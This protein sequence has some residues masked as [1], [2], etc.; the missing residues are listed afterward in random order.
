M[1]TKTKICS[2]QIFWEGNLSATVAVTWVFS[3][4]RRK[5]KAFCVRQF[6]LHRQQSESGKQNV[7]FAPGQNV[8]GL[9]LGGTSA[10]QKTWEIFFIK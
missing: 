9:P 10:R 4:W 3:L 5:G 2:V 6:A 7:V 8:C 1:L